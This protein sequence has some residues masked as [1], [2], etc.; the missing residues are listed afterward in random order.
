MVK[1]ISI[2]NET[3]FTGIS[4]TQ[5]SI[6]FI[7][8]AEV[9]QVNRETLKTD[10]IKVATNETILSV[11][12][13]EKEEASTII[14]DSSTYQLKQTNL[15]RMPGKADGVRLIT[16]LNNTWFT[17]QNNNEFYTGVPQKWKPISIAEHAAII[18][19][20]PVTLIQ[21]SEDVVAIGTVHNGIYLVNIKS[22]KTEEH[23]HYGTGLPDNEIFCLTKDQE[24]NIWAAHELGFTQ[25]TTHIPLHS[26]NHYPGLQGNIQTT[27]WADKTLYVGTST[28]LYKLQPKK[29]T[30]EWLEP[31][32]I[33]N[34]EAKQQA[35]TQQPITEPVSRKKGFFSFLKKKKEQKTE[36]Q[37]ANATTEPANATQNK[38]VYVKRT[39][40]QTDGYEYKKQESIETKI[41]FLLPLADKLFAAGPAGLY[42][43]SST[44][45]PKL[46]FSDP[47]EF[48]LLL[49]DSRL[50]V[51]NENGTV[52]LLDLTGNKQ[53]LFSTAESI[54][55]ATQNTA[56]IWL[57]GTKTLYHLDVEFKIKTYKYSNSQNDATAIVT[58]NNQ[59][60]LCNSDGYFVYS[61]KAVRVID[62]LGKA[63]L[64]YASANTLV[65]KQ[66][67]QWRML[68]YAAP[69]TLHYLNLVPEI[70]KLIVEKNTNTLWVVP[71][72][73]ELYS[74]KLEENKGTTV[75]YPLLVNL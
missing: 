41:S 26:F 8:D 35:K 4:A 74:L 61:N 51:Q 16:S 20:V 49:N 38:I 46:I 33:N 56:G 68:G 53:T 69:G 50:V 22:G 28:G 39:L 58:Y 37:T 71:V 44:Q 32:R 15:V 72:N 52:F 30:I 2:Q 59:P 10:K 40:Q 29:T 47:I 25:I 27:A 7:S 31:V 19:S 6:Y 73:N 18:Q 57:A 54:Q 66:E 13:S 60:V 17:L 43:L 9:W 48:A 3:T 34:P 55:A 21:V 42:Q 12:T 63:N 75:Q 45:K 23:I 1:K 36:Q 11:L 70:R 5:Q 64:F 14:T 24:N 62:S 67:N 65:T